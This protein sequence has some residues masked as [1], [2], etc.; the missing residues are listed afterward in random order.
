MLN[1]LK[2]KT[3][4]QSCLRYLQQTFEAFMAVKTK[5]K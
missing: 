5:D 3:D 2:T 4:K 1:L